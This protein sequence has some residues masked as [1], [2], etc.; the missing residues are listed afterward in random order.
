MTHGVIA[1]YVFLFFLLVSPHSLLLLLKLKLKLWLTKLLFF[2][3]II[4]L[5]DRMIFLLFT[6]IFFVAQFYH[7]NNSRRRCFTGYSMLIC[8]LLQKAKRE[9]TR[10]LHPQF[11]NTALRRSP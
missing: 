4:V 10:V 9:K 8:Y 3:I 2:V 5:F 1:G 11:M 6:I 7:Y